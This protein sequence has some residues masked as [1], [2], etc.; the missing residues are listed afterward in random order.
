M[1]IFFFI[2]TKLFDLLVIM[3]F[4]ILIHRARR[5]LREYHSDGRKSC[6]RASVEPPTPTYKFFFRGFSP[7]EC[8]NSKKGWTVYKQPPG[9]L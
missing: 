7:V 4:I 1:M 8:H 6:L 5:P 9:V 3:Q 2:Y